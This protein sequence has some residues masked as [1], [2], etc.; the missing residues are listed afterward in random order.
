MVRA[1]SSFGQPLPSGFDDRDKAYRLGEP[2]EHRRHYDSWA[3]TYDSEFADAVGYIYPLKVATRVLS[4]AEA[5]DRPVA[6]LGCGTGLAGAPFA[7]TGIA[8][9]GFDISPGMLR[10]AREKDVYRK[11]RTADLTDP[12]GL[13]AGEYGGLISC[14]TFTLGHLG[15]PALVNGLRMART[16]A[17]C[18]IGINSEHFANGGFARSF[19]ELT[20]AGVIGK[21]KFEKVAIYQDKDGADE[22]NAGRLAIFRRLTAPGDRRARRR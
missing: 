11:L 8:I 5:G 6:D 17:L 15:P 4:L 2:D 1:N 16:G 7:G 14:G 21:L 20:S 13:P 9:D 3:E 10:Q 12:Q 19:A 18:V 22:V